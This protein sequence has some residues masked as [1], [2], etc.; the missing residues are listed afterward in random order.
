MCQ[1]DV[2]TLICLIVTEEWRGIQDSVSEVG[3]GGKCSQAHG[4]QEPGGNTQ[5]GTG[6]RPDRKKQHLVP[7]ARLFFSHIKSP[8]NA[9]EN[10]M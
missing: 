2:W 8:S 6:K 4:S 9:E 7:A 3:K 1:H 5:A 10:L